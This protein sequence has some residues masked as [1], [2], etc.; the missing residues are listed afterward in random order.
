MG[1]PVKHGSHWRIREEDV[2]GVKAEAFSHKAG[3]ILLP[4]VGELG[5]YI[6]L[7]LWGINTVYGLSCETWLPN[8]RDQHRVGSIQLALHMV[9]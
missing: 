1:C 8:E 9:R 7:L 4:A 6:V 5:D 3:L 2:S